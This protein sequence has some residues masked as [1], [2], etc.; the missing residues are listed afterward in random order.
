MDVGDVD[1][2]HGGDDEGEGPPDEHHHRRLAV[3]P[4]DALGEGVEVEEDPEVEEHAA[5][6]LEP[7]RPLAVEHLGEGDGGADDVDE[8]D[9]DGGDHEPRPPHHVQVGVGVLLLVAG[10]ELGGELERDVPP[11]HHL[12]DHL[13]HGGEVGGAAGRH[14]ELPVPEPLEHGDPRPLHLQHGE[15]EQR[16]EH[17]G[18]VDVEH[19]GRPLHDE[20]PRHERQRRHGGVEDEEQRRERVGGD[21]DVRHALQRVQERAPEQRVVPREEDLQRTRR[22]PEHLE[23]PLRQVDRRRPDERVRVDGAVARPPPLDVHPVAGHHV[24]RHRAVHP[25]DVAPPPGLLLVRRRRHHHGLRDRR[26]V[27]RHRRL[28]RVR[29]RVRRA[30]DGVGERVRLAVCLLGHRQEPV[31]PLRHR[32]RRR[33]RH[34][35]GTRLGHLE[36]RLLVPVLGEHPTEPREARSAD[37]DP[38]RLEP[39]Q[40]DAAEETPGADVDR[41]LQPVEGTERAVEE[42]TVVVSIEVGGVDALEALRELDE[43]DGVAVAAEHEADAGAERLGV[44][45]VVVAVEVEDEGGVGEHGGGAGQ[46]VHGAGLLLVVAPGALLTC[47]VHQHRQPHVHAAEVQR[48]VGARRR[49]QLPCVARV[50]QQHLHIFTIIYHISKKKSSSTNYYSYIYHY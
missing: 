34:R 36:P 14:P 32:R 50:V 43:R 30:R 29:R 21:V 9:D 20:V 4:E 47:D 15:D 46:R 8:D 38:R 44:V 26:L 49:P 33:R 31:L 18:E 2:E 13:Q 35:L 48:V 45:D 16:P 10:G 37:V 39:V 25:P 7:V 24:L 27:G 11:E 17:D 41:P 5:G 12:G 42:D 1:V 28:R 22:P 6:D 40:R 23:Q 3:L 19:G